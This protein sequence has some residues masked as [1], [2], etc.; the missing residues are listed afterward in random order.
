M[1]SSPVKPAAPNATMTIGATARIGTVCEA[2]IQGIRL[3]S[4][5]R[6]W[7]IAT[8][9]AMPRAVPMAKPSSVAESV[10]QAW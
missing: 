10:T 7:T 3:A 9:S 6:R 4:T 8:A 5:L 2:T 1:G